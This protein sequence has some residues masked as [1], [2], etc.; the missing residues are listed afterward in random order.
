MTRLNVR[1]PLDELSLLNALNLAGIEGQAGLMPERGM[2][3]YDLLK[4][5]IAIHH[6]VQANAVAN[7]EISTGNA[8]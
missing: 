5:F 4:P 3:G 6:P 1:P 7:F 2:R 8:P